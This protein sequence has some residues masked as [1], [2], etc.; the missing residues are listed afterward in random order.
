M[1]RLHSYEEIRTSKDWRP[2]GA[3]G[4]RKRVRTG[5]ADGSHNNSTNKS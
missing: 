1:D 2:G 4:V 3:G 5:L